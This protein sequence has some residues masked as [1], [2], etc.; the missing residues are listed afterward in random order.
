MV[1]IILLGLVRIVHFLVIMDL[2]IVATFTFPAYALD[3]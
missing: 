3:M 1:M 2:I